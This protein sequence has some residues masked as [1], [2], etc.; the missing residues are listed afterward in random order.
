MVQVQGQ[1][2]AGHDVQVL[3]G[4]RDLMGQLDPGQALQGAGD[5]LPDPQ[6]GQV[7]LD[8]PLR[9][10]GAVEGVDVHCRSFFL[11]RRLPGKVYHRPGLPV[12]GGRGG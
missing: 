1:G 9:H 4:D 6:P 12:N 2:P 3:K 8:L 11:L 5:L 7:G 10:L